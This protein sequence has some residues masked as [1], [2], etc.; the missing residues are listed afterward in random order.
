MLLRKPASE[1]DVP[2]TTLGFAC[3]TWMTVKVV[4]CI[5]IFRPVNKRSYVARKRKHVTLSGVWSPSAIFC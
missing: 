4:N 5:A 1:K 3:D 2:I